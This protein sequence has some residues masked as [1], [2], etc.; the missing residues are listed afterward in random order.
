[1]SEPDTEA[2]HAA[3]D[4]PVCYRHPTRETYIRCARCDRPICPECMTSAAVGFQCPECVREG[5]T[6]QRP[7]RT[8]AGATVRQGPP[9][10]TVS[11]VV[12]CAA[13]WVLQITIP[14]LTS[15][16][17]LLGAAVAGGEWYRLVT[18]GFL[19]AGFLHI[20]LNMWVLWVFGQPV[21]AL[22]GRARFLTVYLVSLVAGT[23]ASYVFNSPL[24]PSL[25]ASGAIFGVVGAMIVLGKRLRMPLGWVVSFVV[26]NLAFTVFVSGIDWHAHLGGLA[27]GMALTAAM[28]Y[29][30]RQYRVVAW[31]AATVV[32]LAG[33]TG[34]AVSRTQV[35]QQT[36]E[37]A[38]YWSPAGQQLH[39]DNTRPFP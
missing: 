4:V 20:A 6:A 35:V 32:L 26:L 12:A 7:V 11:I 36:P 24:T 5:R 25:G 18:A 21:E 34:V 27:G 13:V 19:H 39:Q 23:T 29:P 1:M 10:V 22:L 38:F 30:P 33:L 3:S 8:V 28:V 2:G 14:G 37:Y 17:Y 16:F 31:V 15:R 9:V